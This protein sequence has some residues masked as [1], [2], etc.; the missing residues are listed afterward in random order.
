MLNKMLTWWSLLEGLD[1]SKYAYHQ[2][3]HSV[4]GCRKFDTHHFAQLT[5]KT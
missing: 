3:I 2:E 4:F 1:R 5:W